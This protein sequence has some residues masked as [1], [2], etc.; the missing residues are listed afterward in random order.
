MTTEP[1]TI[2]GRAYSQLKAVKAV[3]ANGKRTFSGM[4]TTPA[5]D[6]MGDVV[7]P[8][9][10]KF[11]NPLPLL[12]QHRHD[13]PIGWVKFGKA[14]KDGIPF[15]A[16]VALIPEE[17][18]LKTRIDDA[19]LSIKHGLVAAVSIG[20]SADNWAWVGDYEGIEFQEIECYEL[21]AVTIPA[22]PEALITEVSSAKGAAEALTIIKS[23]DKGA[24][25][26][27]GRPERP[28]PSADLQDPSD[29]AAPSGLE[30]TP[31]IDPA[32]RGHVAKLA[33][34]VRARAPFVINRIHH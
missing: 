13:Q 23:F 16:E 11:K 18:N 8:L 2:T 21:S 15:D 29:V 24:P 7:L 31:P 17:S 3:E 32:Q 30:P 20:F 22:N 19:W 6:R 27:S 33:P 12:W 5:V 28:A 14:T 9:G 34:P 10:V 1:K 4:A 26:D 25:A